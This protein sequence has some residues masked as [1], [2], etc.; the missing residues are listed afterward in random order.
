M[1]PPGAPWTSLFAPAGERLGW[2]FLDR[3]R[4]RRP[5]QDPAP[6]LGQGP[7]ERTAQEQAALEA[8][9]RRLLV[10]WKI[11][12]G[13]ALVGLVAR[14]QVLLH[15]HRPLALG[16]VFGVAAVCGLGVGLAWVGWA[17]AVLR[18]VR[19]RWDR[20]R[21]RHQSAELAARQEWRVRAEAHESAE[22]ARLS[23]VSD[24]QSA[25]VEPGC[26]R[27]DV[28]GGTLWGWEALLTVFAASTLASRGPVT[29]LDLTGEGI[30]GELVGGARAAGV[31][32][33]L[34]ELPEQLADADLLYGMGPGEVTESFIE[35]VHGGQ[36]APADRAGRALDTRI[37]EG[38]CE[39]LAPDGLSMARIAAGVRVL[40]GEPTSAE[41]EL[42]IEE[43]AFLADELFSA[44]YRARALPQL[45][46]IEALAH[47]LAP[48]GART[49]PRPAAALRVLSLNSTW[50]SAAGDFL[51]DVL[52]ASAARTI[53]HRPETVST[54]IIAGADELAARHL[55]RL[56]DLA[57]RRG[58]RVVSMFR[59][60]RENTAHLLGA[61]PVAFMRLGNHQE[62]ER[63]A[64]YIGREHTFTVSQLTH[65]VGGDETHSN[66]DTDGGSDGQGTSSSRESGESWQGWIGQRGKHHGTTHAT[67]STSERTWSRTVQ[68]AA[69]ENW[70]DTTTRQRVFEHQVQ[71]RSLQQLPD[72]ALVMVEHRPA[73]TTV[74][75]VEVNPEIAQLT[76]PATDPA[77]PGADPGMISVAQYR[78]A[79]SRAGGAPELENTTE[80]PLPGDTRG[81]V[82]GARRQ[83]QG[84]R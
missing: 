15:A 31:T 23:A 79:A 6:D 68:I 10:V 18:M 17:Y 27:V 7:P 14:A 48:L 28:V 5:F 2:V 45:Q 72:Y 70:A 83:G 61:G 44:D 67:T 57:D 11:A 82:E 37:L 4:A 49:T 35:A 51:A 76:D 46:R 30:S 58:V 74:R 66:A 54:L 8:F 20:R 80:T 71:P 41:N 19:S 43:R 47:S 34:L 50:R 77:N 60:L 52:I 12:A 84:W 22:V 59:H 25:Y 36:D 16:G 73:G 55:E 64:D 29:V 53:A 21:E 40:M 78:S 13:G 9:G 81:P 56:T 24:W 69:G 42:S 38:L 32:T 75:T 33:D 3:N 39:H 63:A 65:A 1:L 26:R 62:A